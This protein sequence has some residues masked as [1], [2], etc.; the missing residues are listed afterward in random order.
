MK[1]LKS[2]TDFMTDSRLNQNLENYQVFKYNVMK[3]TQET[4]RL[5]R[6][7]SNTYHKSDMYPGKK[8]AAWI[9]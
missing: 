7:S 2:Y 1:H 4:S 8:R 3:E 9:W 5:W 6:M